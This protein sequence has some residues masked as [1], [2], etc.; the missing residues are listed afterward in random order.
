LI[1]PD[2]GEPLDVR[3]GTTVLAAGAGNA[4]LR[5]MLGLP[6]DAMQRRPLHMVLARGDL[7]VLNGHCVDGAATRVTITTARDFEERVIWQIGGQLAERGVT[8]QP[9]ELAAHAQ[10]EL[11]EALPGRSW[12]GVEW[13]TY[14]VDRAEPRTRGG[15][16]P[17]E[18]FASRDGAV[19][20][21]WPT[22][23]ALVP[24][25]AARIRALLPSTPDPVPSPH[26]AALRDWPRPTVALPPWETI[27]TWFSDH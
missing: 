18:S 5:S 20:T 17:E 25:L 26:T 15:L 19:I 27:T 7:P 6:D 24:Q 3:A 4:A 21:A 2:T 8:M 14:R 11:G 23:L 9:D 13:G 22:K 16:R 12:H 1:N 10:R